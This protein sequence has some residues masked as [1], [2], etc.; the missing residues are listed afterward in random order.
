VEKK[1]EG[2]IEDEDVG[3]KSQKIP[4]EIPKHIILSYSRNR[5]APLTL[6]KNFEYLN[7]MCFL[8]KN[9]A[10]ESYNI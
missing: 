10:T 8:R 7:I 1:V 9:M 3:K 2:E 6:I 5:G 4:Y